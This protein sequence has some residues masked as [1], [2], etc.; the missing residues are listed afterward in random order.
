MSITLVML[1]C[2][3]LH[4]QLAMPLLVFYVRNLNLVN[5]K[6]EKREFSNCF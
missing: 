4:G 3:P 5:A 2:C 1:S 6:K